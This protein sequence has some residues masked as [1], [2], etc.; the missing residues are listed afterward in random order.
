MLPL[1]AVR[2]GDRV[3]VVSPSWCAPQ[4]F[5]AEHEVA[6][7]RLRHLFDVEPVE[8]PTTRLQGTAQERARDLM[9][10]FGDP[11]ITAVLATIGGEDQLTVIPHLDPTVVRA[12]PKPFFGYSDNTNL[13]NWLAA[14]G[15]PSVHGSSTQVHLAPGPAVHPGHEATMRAAL[16]GGD[17]RLTP[18]A[19]ISEG[20]QRWGTPES[21]LA[22]DT[23][24]ASEW[25]WRGDRAVR[26][27]VWGGNLE[28]LQWILGVGRWIPEP[29][30][31]RDGVLLLE[32]SEECPT[33]DEVR[34]M[35]RVL[36][37]RGLL[38]P[39]AGLIWARPKVE[40]GPMVP[41]N[42][43]AAAATRTEHREQVLAALD[44]YNPGA[45]AVLDVDC[46][47]TLPQLVLPYGQ[48]VTIDPVA[49][50]LT[51]HFDRVTS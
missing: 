46:G 38:A 33:P 29:E 47:H 44:T 34:R 24:P 39:V 51:A 10:A 11:T 36:G 19:R 5:P 4:H 25:V 15:V 31:L 30:E 40:E 2:P 32:T 6:L 27:R 41:S 50:A 3:A 14:Q 35:L 20:T 26:G 45:V 1:Y 21:V 22:A 7:R 48:D 37:E 42:V 43:G 28:V 18:P 23:Y 13:L 17:V 9:A 8:Y 49:G 16:F 12:N